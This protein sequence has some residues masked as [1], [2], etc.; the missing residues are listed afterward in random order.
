MPRSKQ[1][2]SKLYNKPNNC[3]LN[4]ED[5]RHAQAKDKAQVN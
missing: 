5:K 1:R 4:G 3:Y 2:N